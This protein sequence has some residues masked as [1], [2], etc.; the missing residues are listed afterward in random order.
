MSLCAF[1][2]CSPMP[3]GQLAGF[4]ECGHEQTGGGE[5]GEGGGGCEAAR[6]NRKGGAGTDRHRPI[7]A[8]QSSGGEVD[9]S[10]GDRSI[11]TAAPLENVAVGADEAET[12][13]SVGTDDLA[14]PTTAREHS[15]GELPASHL[16]E[17]IVTVVGELDLGVSQQVAAMNVAAAGGGE[18]CSASAWTAAREQV[19]ILG[20]VADRGCPLVTAVSE[21]LGR[22][23]GATRPQTNATS[24]TDQQRYFHEL[25]PLRGKRRFVSSVAKLNASRGCGPTL[26]A[27]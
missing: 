12:A 11:R 27:M 6:T 26:E 18:T 17:G 5:T 8:D 24:E 2:V 7:V 25:P 3:G 15:G 1:G 19:A 9:S 4:R 16:P 10:L 23:A 13:N 22:L 14:T 20:P 21:R